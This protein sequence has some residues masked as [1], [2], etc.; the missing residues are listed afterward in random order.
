MSTQPPPVGIGAGGWMRW[1]WRTLT[2]MRVALLLLFLLAL[3]A[4]P[5]S[6]F[7]Q[8]GTDAAAVRAYIANNP[9]WGPL[10]DRLGMFE[11]FGSPW[12]AAVYLLLMVSLA[13][14]VIPRAAQHWRAMRAR[15]PAAPSRLSRLPEYRT[16]ETSAEPA[17]VIA[18]AE[19]LLRAQHWRTDSRLP[20]DEGG[21]VAAERG[22]LREFGNLLFHLSLLGLL[23]AVAIGG[24]FGSKGQV[25]VREGSSFTNSLTQFDSFS[26]GRLFSPDRMPPFTLRLDQFR[27]SYQETGMQRGAPREFAADVAVRRSPDAPETTEVVGVNEP[28]SIDG[29]KVYLV[30]HGYAPEVRI[31]DAKGRVVFDDAVVFLPQDS[32]FTSDG[33]IKVPDTDPQ[34]GFTAVFLPTAERDSVKGGF[35][36]FPAPMRPEMFMSVW[37]GDLGLDNGMPQS[38][39]RLD[40]AAMERVGLTAIKP[41]G[42]WTLPQGLGTLEFVGIKEYATFEVARDPGSG[43]AL[44]AAALS[45]A[46]LCLSLFIRRRRIWLRVSDRADGNTLVE[47]A[48]LA[49]TEGP[50]L[51]DEVDD[52]AASIAQATKGA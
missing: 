44:L 50:G 28:L 36:S 6:V 13:G 23:V 14:C 42:S 25:I 17:A 12:F 19:S 39:Y 10:L 3:A 7:P 31:T 45:L 15:P 9:Q 49:R 1:A 37:K 35:S 29:T 5:G 16:F 2:S 27:A 46:G 40:T 26:S 32:N 20:G 8:R 48:G 47:V 51:A 34:L 21:W 33:V 22:Y 4:V 43:W 24:L 38:V 11:V 52:I 41:G 30:G 18:A